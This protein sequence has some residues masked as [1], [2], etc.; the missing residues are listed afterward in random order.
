MFSSPVLLADKQIECILCP[1]EVVVVQDFH[2]TH[3]VRIKV[4]CN[5]TNNKKKQDVLSQKQ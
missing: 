1:Q 4:T 2:S 3:P 5:L